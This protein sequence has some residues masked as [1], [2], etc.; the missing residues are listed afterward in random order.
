VAKWGWRGGEKSTAGGEIQ[1][2]REGYGVVG[3]GEL[4][5]VVL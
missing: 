3:G 1:D 2:G 5:S 4:Q